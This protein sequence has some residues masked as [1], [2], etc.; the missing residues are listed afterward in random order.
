M[1]YRTQPTAGAPLGPLRPPVPGPAGPTPLTDHRLSP[2]DRDLSLADNVA[3]LAS[4]W[5]L[6]RATLALLCAGLVVALLY[7]GEALLV[8]FALAALLAFVLDPLVTRLQRWRLPRAV[9]VVGVMAILAVVVAGASVFV[10]GQAVA[11]GRDLPTYQSTVQK[12]LRALRQEMSGRGPLDDLSRMLDVVGGELDATRRVLAQ[13]AT[14]AGAPA[15]RVVMAPVEPTAMQALR[16]LV[17]PLLGPVGTAGLVLVFLLFILLERHDLRDRLLRLVGGDLHR[18]TEAL[19][20]AGERVSRYLGMQVLVNLGYAVPLSLGL[21]LLGVPGALL[22]GV[23]GGLLRFVP[24]IGPLVAAVFPLAMAFAVDPGWQLLLSTLALVLVLELVIN[25]LVEP[26]LYGASTGLAPTAVVVSAAFWTLLWGPVGLILATPLTVCLVVM[27]RHLPRLAWLDVLLG[28]EP[29]FDPPTRLYQRLLDGEVEEAVELALGHARGNAFQAAC[30]DTVL[31]VMALVADNQHR[32]ASAEQRLRLVHGLGVVLQELLAHAQQHGRATAAALSGGSTASAEGAGGAAG[33]AAAANA[34]HALASAQVLCVGARTEVD[35]LAAQLLAEVLGQHGVAAATLPAGALS[36]HRIESL[37]PGAAQVLVLCSLGRRPEAQ[38]RF[39]CRRLRRLHPGLQPVLALWHGGAAPEALGPELAD[40][41]WACSL[42]DAVL[43]VSTVLRAPPAPLPADPHDPHGQNHPRDPRDLR[44]AP[45]PS[46]V[47]PGP[48]PD[49]GPA[50]AAPVLATRSP[51]AD[52]PSQRPVPDMGVLPN[53]FL[54][55]ACQA[56]LDHAVQRA[57]EV[58]DMPMAC[59]ALPLQEGQRWVSTLGWPLACAPGL[60]LPAGL[61]LLPEVM[62]SGAAVQVADM[63]RHPGLASQAL[64]VD[65]GVRGL[66]AVPLRGADGRVLG[67]LV[68]ADRQARQ[69]RPPE[70]QLLQ[71]LADDLAALAPLGLPPAAAPEGVAGAR[72][73]VTRLAASAAAWDLGA[74]AQAPG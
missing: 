3:P 72:R 65:A 41:P 25:N 5:P 43:R 11:L 67:A 61:G 55:P 34:A 31:P 70:L 4:L 49:T 20:E 42:D 60:T 9:A 56:P 14:P 71:R 36:A 53:P 57:A 19:G 66:C 54:D 51:A 69:L 27:G 62:A 30:N 1:P 10:S 47:P 2:A 8:P 12:K 38:L 73:P 32:L 64:L 63:A 22:F 18:S 44:T 37:D 35:A 40:L 48:G 26:W 59:V 16:Q 17:E 45:A 7:V 68:V 33:G 23:L 46:P 21:W 52:G 13:G 28:S 15:Q 29:V 24:Y 74:A 6:L 58:F 39:V 50:A